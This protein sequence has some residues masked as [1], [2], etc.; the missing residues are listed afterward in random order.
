[1]TIQIVT[2]DLFASNAQTLVNAINCVGVIGITVSNSI[3]TFAL[4]M[5]SSEFV[6][7]LVFVYFGSR[8]AVQLPGA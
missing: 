4:W 7:D 3:A 8:Q 1:M 2:G 6:D 5:D